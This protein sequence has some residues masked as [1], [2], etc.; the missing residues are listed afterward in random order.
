MTIAEFRTCVKILS[1]FEDLCSWD[2]CSAGEIVQEPNEV[3]F[4]FGGV[5]RTE[6][7]HDRS[8]KLGRE[9]LSTPLTPSI[10]PE[11]SGVRHAESRPYLTSSYQNTG[12]WCVSR[13]W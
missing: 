7:V 6:A 3:R 5:G 8:L 2:H 1:L 4:G 11:L 9:R 13:Q 12:I 10:C